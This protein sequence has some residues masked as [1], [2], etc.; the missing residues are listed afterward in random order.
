LQKLAETQKM[1]ASGLPFPHPWRY[2]FLHL[3]QIPPKLTKLLD[4]RAKQIPEL[5]VVSMAEG[6]V[7]NWDQIPALWKTVFLSERV[8]SNHEVQTVV[9]AAIVMRWNEI[10]REL[11]EFYRRQTKHSDPRIRACMA[12]TALVLHDE[13]RPEVESLY[14]PTLNDPD[15]TVPLTVVSN[16]LVDSNHARTYATNLIEKATPGMAAHILYGILDRGIPDV[17]WKKEIARECLAKGG[18]LSRAVLFFRGIGNNLEGKAAS[19]TTTEICTF[20]EELKMAWIC[21][22]ANNK[23]A[24]LTG[25]SVKKVV[26][27]MTDKYKLPAL[28]HL[29]LQYHFLPE[30]ARDYLDQLQSIG[31]IESEQII[32]GISSRQA[33][34]AKTRTIFGF[35]VHLFVEESED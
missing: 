19:Y 34:D 3:D 15:V 26:E 27:S 35:P 11:Q 4:S 31:G 13:T 16:G 7:T 12:S 5:F 14:T 10:S 17:E 1:G 8:I 6:L 32:E 23:P 28:L 30:D 33:V 25:D 2:L 20:P 29:S 9:A 21:R 24:T 18:D 22:R